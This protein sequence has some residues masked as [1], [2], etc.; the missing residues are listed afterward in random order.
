[1][2]EESSKKGQPYLFWDYR[3]IPTQLLY[4]SAGQRWNE[5]KTGQQRACPLF[6]A[7]LPNSP[8]E[9]RAAH[10]NRDVP[11]KCR[12]AANARPKFPVLRM[13]EEFD[14]LSLAVESDEIDAYGSCVARGKSG[15]GVSPSAIERRRSDGAGPRSGQS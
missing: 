4:S 10:S 3:S 11:K 1:M 14:A 15:E 5:Q 6:K 2:A 13:A 9:Y 12:F 8:R 7:N